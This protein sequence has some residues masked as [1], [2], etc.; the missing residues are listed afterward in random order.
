MCTQT[1]HGHFLCPRMMFLLSYGIQLIWRSEEHTSELQSHSDLVCRLL[2]EKST[3]RIAPP[4]ATCTL[5]SAHA[6]GT[7]STAASP[8]LTAPAA[9][10][11]RGVRLPKHSHRPR[12][13][14]YQQH[15]H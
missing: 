3:D 11:R 2:L 7:T 12:R 13:P 10:A 6:E 9:K 1:Y 4:P 15:A 14:H 5:L 8:I